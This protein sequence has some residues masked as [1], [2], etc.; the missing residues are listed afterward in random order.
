M[1][2]SVRCVLPVT[3]AVEEGGSS[4]FNPLAE[5]RLNA[6]RD[7]ADAQNVANMI[8]RTGEDSP[9]ERYWQDAAV[10]ITTGMILHACYAAAAEGRVACLSDLANAF[11]PVQGAA[12]QKSPGK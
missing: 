8:V 5:V 1:Q 7:V 10:S 3:L 11:A 12:V 4:R 9:Q 6:N 2:I